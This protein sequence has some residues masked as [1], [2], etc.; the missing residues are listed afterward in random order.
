MVPFAWDIRQD[1]SYASHSADAIFE[2][3][4]TTVRLRTISCLGS[5]SP[6]DAQCNQARTNEAFTIYPYVTDALPL[7]CTRGSASPAVS[8][9]CH[10]SYH[11][12]HTWH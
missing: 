2:T 6:L 12:L 1:A 8:V 10:M 4:A 9:R 11:T 5:I 7:L 3:T